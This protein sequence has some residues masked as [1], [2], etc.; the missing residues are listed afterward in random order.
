MKDESSLCSRVQMKA[1]VALELRLGSTWMLGACDY[2][3]PEHPAH[4]Y[5]LFLAPCDIRQG[6]LYKYVMPDGL[7]SPLLPNI[8]HHHGLLRCLQCRQ[9]SGSQPSDPAFTTLTPLFQLAFYG[10]Y[11]SNSINIVIHVI[12]VPMILWSIQRLILVSRC[13]L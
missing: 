9:A 1:P 5:S 6:P 3:I 8:N 10:A 4:H 2:R 11:H 13:S 12:C 7:I